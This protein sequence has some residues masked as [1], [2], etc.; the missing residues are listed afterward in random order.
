MEK[1][2]KPRIQSAAEVA[3]RLEQ[4]AGETTPISPRASIRSPWSA[5]PLPGGAEDDKESLQDTG[6][7]DFSGGEASTSQ[8]SQGTSGLNSAGHETPALRKNSRSLPI[9]Q[10]L[11]LPTLT[12]TAIVALTLMI[13]IPASMLVGALIAS[14]MFWLRG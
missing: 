4:W 8:N 10:A 2:P 12:P 14:L 9:P 13:S 6:G 7:D 1:D 3:A 11:Q 5:P